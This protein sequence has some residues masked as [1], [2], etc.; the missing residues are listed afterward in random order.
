MAGDQCL[1]RHNVSTN[2]SPIETNS[3]RVPN[4]D[5]FRGDKFRPRAIH[6]HPVHGTRESQWPTP[7]ADVPITWGV[8]TGYVPYQTRPIGHR[9][10]SVRCSSAGHIR[11]VAGGQRLGLK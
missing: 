1:L 10:N 8:V 11:A 2:A 9:E 4:Q 6:I 3:V 5:Q 7:I